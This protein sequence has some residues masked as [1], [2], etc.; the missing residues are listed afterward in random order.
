MNFSGSY[1]QAVGGFTSTAHRNEP[2]VKSRA[3]EYRREDERGSG[4][5]IWRED[6]GRRHSGDPR[7]N[8]IE[9]GRRIDNGAPGMSRA[10]SQGQGRR[11]GQGSAQQSVCLDPRRALPNETLPDGHFHNCNGVLIKDMVVVSSAALHMDKVAQET[12][13]MQ[14]HVVIVRCTGSARQARTSPAWRLELEQDVSPGSIQHHREAGAGFTYIKLNRPETAKHALALSPLQCRSG[15]LTLHRW[16]PAF[17]PLMPKLR[18]SL[19]ISLNF[20]PLEYVDE[21]DYI[22][23]C[24]RKVLEVDYAAR[25]HSILR[26]RVEINEGDPWVSRLTLPKAAQKQGT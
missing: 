10:G 15:T 1:R 3:A 14:E 2:G 16:I 5:R 19:W 20:L 12:T 9:M 22:A 7:S 8:P 4:N 21:A 26:Y 6:D 11:E 23:A 13:F 25:A 18:M 24:V 17:N